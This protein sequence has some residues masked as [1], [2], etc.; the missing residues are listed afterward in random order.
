L[1]SNIAIDL[2]APVFFASIGLEMNLSS[3]KNLS[4]ILIVLLIAFISKIISG[5]LAGRMAG[6]NHSNSLTLGVNTRGIM[7]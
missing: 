3:L 4:L 2:L 7:E 1:K 6:F 5:Y